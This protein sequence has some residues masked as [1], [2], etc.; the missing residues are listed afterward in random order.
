MKK[1]YRQIE[2]GFEKL[3]SMAIL[4]LGNSLTFIVAFCTVIYWFTNPQFSQHNV[5]DKIG[6]LILGLTFLSLF[7]IQKSFNRF[8][9]ALHLKINE[10]IATNAAANNKLI[11][12]EEKTEHEIAELSKEYAELVE[13]AHKEAE[14]KNNAPE[15][16]ETPH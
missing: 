8:S 13:I 1:I 9:A 5:H 15:T 11:S 12:V 4:T 7:V 10:L 6:D 2:R 16:V 3:T 14:E